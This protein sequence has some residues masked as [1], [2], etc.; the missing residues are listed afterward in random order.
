MKTCGKTAYTSEKMARN[1]AKWIE[2]KG[3]ILRPYHCPICFLWHLTSQVEEAH[4]DHTRENK[5][6]HGH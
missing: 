6:R 4:W 1:Q 5:K 2:H 3:K